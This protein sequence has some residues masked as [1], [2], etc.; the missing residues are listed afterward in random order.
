[1]SEKEWHPCEAD[2][3]N[4]LLRP[5]AQSDTTTVSWDYIRKYEDMRAENERLRAAL[6]SIAKNTCCD[7]CQEAALVARRALEGK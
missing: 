6:T 2:R 4:L 7:R 1:M 5:A 3:D